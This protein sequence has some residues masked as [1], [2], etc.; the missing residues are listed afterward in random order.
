MTNVI[1]T[2]IFGIEHMA[3][4][5]TEARKS[6]ATMGGI[7][8]DEELEMLKEEDEE[9]GVPDINGASVEKASKLQ[10]SNSI[11]GEGFKSGYAL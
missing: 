4:R 7:M 6:I 3:A 2:S 9:E 11:L 5:K 10:V 8:E 1:R